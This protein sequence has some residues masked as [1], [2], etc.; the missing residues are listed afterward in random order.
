MKTKRVFGRAMLGARGA[1]AQQ[2]GEGET[3]AGRDFKRGLGLLT[4]HMGTFAHHAAL[5]DNVEVFDRAIGGSN[6]AFTGAIEAQLALLDQKRQVS[7][8][9]LVEGR[10]SLQKLHGAVNVLQHRGF[11]CL[12]KRI[13][14]TH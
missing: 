4:P 12:E 8:F 6:D 1:L 10:E 14:F 7:V 3:L 2:R 11:S 9:H 13:R 5:L